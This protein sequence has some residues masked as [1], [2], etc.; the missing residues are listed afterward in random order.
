MAP[1][2]PA[3]RVPRPFEHGPRADRSAGAARTVVDDPAHEPSSPSVTT[4]PTSWPPT[5]RAPTTRGRGD[6]GVFQAPFGLPTG[7]RVHE[8]CVFAYDNTPANELSLAVAYTELG[9]ADRDAITGTRINTIAGTGTAATPRYRRLCSTP[10]P[11]LVL[12]DLRRRQRGR[13]FGLA[14]LLHPG[15]ARRLGPW[16]LIGWGGA[17]VRWS[18][19]VR[20]R[21]LGGP[22][23]TPNRRADRTH[24]RRLDSRADRGGILNGGSFIHG[25][26]AHGRQA[27]ADP[28]G[29]GEGLRPQGLLRRPGLRDRASGADVADGTIYLYFR[30]KEDILVS[31][32]DEVMAE[33]LG[34]ARARAGRRLRARRPACWRSPSTTCALLGG[35]RDLAVVFQVELRQSTKF[36]ERFTASWLQDYFALVARGASRQGQREGI[37]ARRPAAQAGDARPSSALWTRWSRPGSSDG[38]DYD[39]RPAGGAPSS[40]SSCGAPPLPASAAARAGPARWPRRG[41]EATDGG[42]HPLRHLLP[43]GRHLREARAPASYKQDGAWHDISSDE[44][45]RAVEEL[46]LGLRALG[47]ERGRPGR[48]SSPR[49]GPSGRSPTWPR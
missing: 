33:H 15:G 20:R 34:R 26:A 17:A 3:A 7:S 21:P 30:N 10:S 44:F 14:H 22:R 47:V 8:I 16:P 45:R 37:A 46:S 9:D 12:R 31:L 41:G 32:F 4:R 40:T 27:P 48:P 25:T 35:N 11:G 42:P 13:H 38:K 49:T 2:G 6:D 24:E 18:P 29:G 19:P 36:M 39:L 28:A 23:Q 1:R 43:V 5:A